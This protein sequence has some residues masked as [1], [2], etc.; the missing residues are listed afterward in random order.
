MYLP[1][2]PPL[3]KLLGVGLIVFIFSTFAL[4]MWIE[5][6]EKKRR[7]NLTVPYMLVKAVGG[8]ATITGFIFTLWIYADLESFVAFFSI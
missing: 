5:S 2:L 3:A 8:V 1:Y 4:A 6:I 7:I